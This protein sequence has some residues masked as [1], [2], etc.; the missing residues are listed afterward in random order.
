MI[1]PYNSKEDLMSRKRKSDQESTETT[2][3]TETP[4]AVAEAPA[5]EANAGG[6]SF[7][8]RV[9]QRKSLSVP[10][11]FGIAK[12]YVVGVSLFESK[13]DRQ[14]AIQFGEGRPEDKPSQAVIDKMKE[15]GF[16]WNAADRIWAI[17]V[18]SDSAMAAR[19]DAES[20]FQDI[21]KMIRQEKGIAAGQE[22]PF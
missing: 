8:D 21:C 14:M 20:L 18:R 13:R 12:D 9:G 22:V 6:R 16:R 2:T 17:P 5:A 11:P 15:A 7:T 10:D 3:P 1:D 4:T 19:I